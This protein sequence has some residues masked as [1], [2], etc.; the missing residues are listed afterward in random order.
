MRYRADISL[1]LF[2]SSLAVVLIVFAATLISR[3]SEKGIGANF[4]ITV[5]LY[6]T[7]IMIALCLIV[8]SFISTFRRREED[9]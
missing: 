3:L 6:S 8:F 4:Y 1:L 2:N 9:E 5:T 7:V